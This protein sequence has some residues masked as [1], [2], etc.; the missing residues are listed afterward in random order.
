MSDQSSRWLTSAKQV[1]NKSVT[2]TFKVGA[3]FLKEVWG[4]KHKWLTRDFFVCPFVTPMISCSQFS[5]IHR[6]CSIYDFSV[7]DEAISCMHE[8]IRQLNTWAS[9]I[10]K[11][12]GYPLLLLASIS[13]TLPY[14]CL[15]LLNHDGQW[16]AYFICVRVH[17]HR[18]ALKSTTHI[19]QYD[20][21][22][23]GSGSPRINKRW[24][25]IA[26]GG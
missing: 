16:H 9:C 11:N 2:F 21:N 12:S 26:T 22:S 1:Y 19:G 17:Y 25:D 18:A 14:S 8:R 7:F 4:L 13:T 3:G 23:C 5:G 6:I 20:G 24:N 15:I 10:D